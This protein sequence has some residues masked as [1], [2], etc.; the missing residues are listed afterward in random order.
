MKNKMPDVPLTL[1][2]RPHWEL[3]GRPDC[4]LFF[5][6]LSTA[7][8]GAT[9]LFVEGTSISRAVDDY[10]RSATELGEY[11]PGRQTLWPQPK[12]YRLP[13]NGVILS[14][15]ATLA[16]RSAAPELLDH[17]SIYIG[18]IALL[19]YPDAFAND[20]RVF[21]SAEAVER[22]IQVFANILGLELSC[23]E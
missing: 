15:L 21:I 9:T 8:P 13:F 4:A 17:L 5:S 10:L 11:L 22:N 20:C 19:E 2:N 16:E 7:F 14:G 18:S 3:R 12:Q 1:W 23:I 6:Q